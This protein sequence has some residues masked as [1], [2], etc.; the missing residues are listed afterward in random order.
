MFGFDWLPGKPVFMGVRSTFGSGARTF[1]AVCVF[2]SETLIH[3]RHTFAQ[4]F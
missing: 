1:F 2:F 3:A 4:C